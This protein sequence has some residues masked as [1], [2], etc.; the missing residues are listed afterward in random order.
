MILIYIPVCQDQDIRSLTDDSVYFDEQI[1]NGFFQARILIISDRDLCNFESVH[2]HVLDLQK[3]G[4][5]Q[6]RVIYPEHLTIFFFL[7]Q[8]VSVFSNVDRSGCNNLLTDRINWRV[9]NLGK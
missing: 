3:I 6:N 7:L 8:Q 2:I 9:R 1:F 4:I 5:G